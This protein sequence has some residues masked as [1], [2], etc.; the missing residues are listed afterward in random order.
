MSILFPPLKPTSRV[1]CACFI[2]QHFHFKKTV[3]RTT[4]Q[5]QK[6]VRTLACMRF[7]G[8]IGKGHKNQLER[9]H[10]GQS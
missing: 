8:D 2:I 1:K 7:N 6:D 4:K 5:V 10:S 9:I 3:L